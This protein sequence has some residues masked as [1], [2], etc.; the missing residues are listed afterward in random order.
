MECSKNLI[1]FILDDLTN[2]RTFKRTCI[3]YARISLGIHED[4]AEELYQELCLR[5]LSK[6]R[7]TPRKGEPKGYL[8]QAYRNL[9]RGH[10]RNK[11]NRKETL[12]SSLFDNSEGED[13]LLEVIDSETVSPQ[14][15]LTH[16]ED[17]ETLQKVI[18]T[19]RE[20]NQKVLIKRY[21][22]GKSHKEIAQDT[23]YKVS[24]VKSRIY[25]SIRK[26]RSI[27]WP[28]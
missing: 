15:L 11:R 25:R 13:S 24:S 3:S 17:E 8:Y 22:E 5:A 1:K 6:N 18:G 7:Y 16:Q 28:D 27:T 26:L 2:G 12:E 19:L 4:T 20:R 14:E 9:C 23:G 10:L 21:F